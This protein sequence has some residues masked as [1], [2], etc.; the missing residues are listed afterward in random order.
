[1]IE[2]EIKVKLIID[3]E[4]KR[5]VLVFEDFDNI[6]QSRDFCT[7]IADYLNIT[8]IDENIKTTRTLH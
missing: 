5:V 2:P 3:E 6:Q 4:T 8:I 7:F 1:M